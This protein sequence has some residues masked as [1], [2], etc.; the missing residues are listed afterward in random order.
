MVGGEVTADGLG[1]QQLVPYRLGT[2]EWMVANSLGAAFAQ[3]E[4]CF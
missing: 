4:S 3:V 2:L 1:R